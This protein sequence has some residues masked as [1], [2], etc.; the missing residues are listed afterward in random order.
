MSTGKAPP[1]SRY[2]TI[3][4]GDL[5]SPTL[6]AIGWPTIPNAPSPD[7]KFNQFF[8][9]NSGRSFDYRDL[10]GVLNRQPP[11]SRETIPP[12]VPRVDKDGNEA[13]GVPSVQL[14]VPLGAYTGWNEAAAGFERGGGSGFFG[15][16]IPFARTEAERPRCGAS[17][18]SSKSPSCGLRWINAQP[19]LK[20]PAFS[21]VSSRA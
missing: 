13:S 6:H 3:A 8:D 4:G 9:Y 12:L 11:A 10:S 18:S 15:G 14:L 1:P 19:D 2:P 7:G 17:I 5:V 20:R 16:S 21:S